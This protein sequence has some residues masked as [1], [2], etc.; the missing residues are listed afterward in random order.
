MNC[1]WMSRLEALLQAFSAHEG[2]GPI[3]Q[4]NGGVPGATSMFV[5]VCV[6]T[7]VPSHAD[8]VFVE[9]ASWVAAGR[10]CRPLLPAAAGRAARR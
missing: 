9:F 10:C 8:V 6:K 1:T 7:F 3:T 2:F 4:A 5:S